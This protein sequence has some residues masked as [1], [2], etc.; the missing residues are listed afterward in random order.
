MLASIHLQREDIYITNIENIWD[1]EEV[2]NLIKKQLVD[3]K[4]G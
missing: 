3:L 4:G 2:E 1:S